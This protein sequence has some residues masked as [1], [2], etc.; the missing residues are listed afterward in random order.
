MDN[1]KTKIFLMYHG[2]VKDKSLIPPNREIGA[3]L[4]DVKNESFSDLPHLLC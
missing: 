3:D 1:N 4:Y 2:I